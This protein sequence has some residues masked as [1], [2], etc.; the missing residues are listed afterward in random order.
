MKKFELPT[1]MNDTEL[2]KLFGKYARFIFG[3]YVITFNNKDF[4]SDTPSGLF[5]KVRAEYAN[6]LRK[7]AA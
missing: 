2:F 5:E 1:N 3:A 6:Y 7:K 4:S